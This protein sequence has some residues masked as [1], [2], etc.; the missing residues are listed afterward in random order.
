MIFC[1]EKQNVRP[2]TPMTEFVP[3]MLA[4]TASHAFFTQEKY[5]IV[6]SGGSNPTHYQLD[7]GGIQY[8]PR[9]IFSNL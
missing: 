3:S 7:H 4:S 2:S 1:V 9:S 5:C 8:K 6:N